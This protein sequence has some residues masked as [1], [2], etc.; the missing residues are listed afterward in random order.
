MK[1]PLRAIFL[2]AGYTLLFPQV[3]KLAQDL[4]SAGFPA[5]VE[6][7]HQAERAGKK[8][9]DE[10]LWPQ[11]RNGRIPR[12]TNHVFWEQYLTALMDQLRPPAEARKE[13]IDRVLGGFRDIHT[14]SKVLPDTIPT[15]QKLKSAGYYLAVISNS[16]G[17]VEGEL[18]RAGLHDY[19]EF[20][21]D[22]S[23]VGVE[24]PHPEIFELAL[25]RAGFK[26][27][28]SIYVGDTHPI[29]IGGAELAGLRGV[30]IDRVGA[31]PDAQCPRITSI[32]ELADLVD[33]A[34]H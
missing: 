33:V 34:G 31:Y 13:V 3:E 19:L 7:F 8:K 11:I 23:V 12:T 17:T 14:W 9:L 24:K 22:S 15:L 27:H 5:R 18:Q 26:P 21:I 28:E 29:D 32:S 2:D 30:L 4:E 25:N 16:D 20:V 10:V 1:T 6:Q